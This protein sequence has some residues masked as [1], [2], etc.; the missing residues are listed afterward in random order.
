MKK[1]VW[2]IC[3][4]LLFLF[5]FSAEANERIKFVAG[6]S[7]E[8]AAAIEVWNTEHL[9]DIQSLDKECWV[10]F[11]TGNNDEWTHIKILNY[12]MVTQTNAPLHFLDSNGFGK[13]INYQVKSSTG[14]VVGKGNVFNTSGEK[15]ESY[16]TLKLEKNAEYKIRF[17]FESVSKGLFSVEIKNRE[18]LLGDTREEAY[19]IAPGTGIKKWNMSGWG[20]VDYIDLGVADHDRKATFYLN[21][22][23]FDTNYFKMSLYDSFGI[24]VDSKTC[25]KGQEALLEATLKKDEA[26]YLEIK[27]DNKQAWFGNYNFGWCTNLA[28][29]PANDFQITKEATCTENGVQSDYCLICKEYMN[30]ADLPA[31]GHSPGNAVVVQEATC[32]HTGLL[33]VRCVECRALLESDELPM[34]DHVIGQMTCIKPASCMEAGLF[35]QHCLVCLSTLATETPAALGHTPGVWVDEPAATCTADGK[36]V[37]RCTVC[38]VI[39]QE[40]T[41]PA[42]GHRPMDWQITR[43]AGCLQTGLNQKLCSDCGIALETETLDATGHHYTEWEVLSVFDG[44]TAGEQRRHCTGCGDTQYEYTKSFFDML[45]M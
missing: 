38:N 43:E 19:P 41:V 29:A 23:Q 5:A 33:E 45:G 35:E 18:D 34:I 39:L 11:T 14:E 9:I 27:V 16:I 26:Y 36:R 31:L 4:S 25:K 28:H 12:S 1:N 7:S 30:Q 37:Q 17:W 6:N 10:K 13:G 15:V 21:N 22:F 8:N 40:E 24:K 44:Q 3:F 32:I 20:D 2:F 42:H